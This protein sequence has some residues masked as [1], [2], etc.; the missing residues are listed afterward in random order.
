L[1]F[2]SSTSRTFCSLASLLPI[3]IVPL[4][5]ILVEF[6]FPKE[7]DPSLSFFKIRNCPYHLSC[8]LNNHCQHTDHVSC[9]ELVERVCILLCCTDSS[10]LSILFEVPFCNYCYFVVILLEELSFYNLWPYVQSCC[11][12]NILLQYSRIQTCCS[13]CSVFH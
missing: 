13:F 2:I 6:S 8:A 4:P 5:M 12:C 1:F 9:V 7:T 10:S 11:T 3:L